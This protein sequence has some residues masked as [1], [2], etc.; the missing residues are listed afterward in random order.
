MD[1]TNI[2]APKL[3]HELILTPNPKTTL[4]VVFLFI[5]WYRWESLFCRAKI[6]VD[7]VE[8]DDYYHCHMG[9]GRGLC[10]RHFIIYLFINTRSECFK[11]PYYKGLKNLPYYLL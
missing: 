3:T 8:G 2:P 4:A 10:S 6:T 9:F 11:H 7:N 5:D 1:E